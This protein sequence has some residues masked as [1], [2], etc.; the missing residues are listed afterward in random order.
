MKK[1]YTP[2]TRSRYERKFVVKTLSK[3]GVEQIIKVH[4]AAFSEI[5]TTRNI[6]NIYLDTPNLTFYLDNVMGKSRRKKMR[7]RWYGD[8]FGEIKKPVLEYKL[9]TGAVGDKISFPLSSFNLSAGFEIQ[10]LKETFNKSDLPEWVR[11]DLAG[12]EPH[13]LNRYTRKYFL[14]FDKSFRITLD[15]DL[16]YRDIGRQN[17]SFLK[18]EINFSDTVLELKYNF[19]KD[20]KSDQISKYLPFRLTKSS[21]YVNGIDA[22]KQGIAD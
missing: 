16:N 8:L 14:S 19:D 15:M 6:N 13:L 1:D 2:Q 17:N 7:I 4:P 11:N 22:F 10:Q 3:Y 21:K 9:K 18:H 12:V 20:D 5:F